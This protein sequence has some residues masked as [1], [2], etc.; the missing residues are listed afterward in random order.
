[1]E[2]YTS[3]AGALA[4]HEEVDAIELNVSC[5]NVADGLVFGSDPQRLRALIR[6]VRSAMARRCRLIVKLSPN[7]PDIV[8]TAAAAVEGGA[9]ALSLINT[10]TAMVVDVH[11]R[12]PRL[13][14]GTGGLSGPAIRPLAV[15]AVHRVYRHV[16]KAAGVPIIGLGGI[17]HWTDAAEFLLAGASALSIGTALFVDPATPLKICKGLQSYLAQ[18]GCS[19]LS[20]I[21]GTLRMPGE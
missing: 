19:S 3:V 6:Q 11:S 9:D 20:Q 4:E 21:V 2:D 1:V 17:Q 8:A 7:A 15:Y 5:P 13:A 18:Q 16:A 14:N 12:R 10:Y